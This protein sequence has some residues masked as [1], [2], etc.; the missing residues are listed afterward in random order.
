MSTDFTEIEQSE[1]REA[2]Q[3]MIDLWR[4][5]NVKSSGEQFTEEDL[6]FIIK[7]AAIVP[8][9][10]I[11]RH[12]EELFKDRCFKFNV[13]TKIQ[14]SDEF[15]SKI[16]NLSKTD[17]IACIWSFMINENFLDLTKCKEYT[18]Y[19]ASS[20]DDKAKISYLN[21]NKIGQIKDI[22]LRFDKDLRMHANPSKVVRSLFDTVLLSNEAKLKVVINLLVRFPYDMLNRSLQFWKY[23]ANIIDALDSS[24]MFVFALGEKVTNWYQYIE[25]SEPSPSQQYRQVGRALNKLLLEDELEFRQS[26]Y[27]LSPILSDYFSEKQFDNFN[28]KYRQESYKNSNFEQIKEVKGEDIR[29]YYLGSNYESPSG[30]LGH[31]CMRYSNCQE[32]LDIYVLNTDI[33]HMAVILNEEDKLLARCIVWFDGDNYY[34]DRVYAVNGHRHDELLSYFLSKEIKSV[35]YGSVEYLTLDIYKLQDKGLK[36]RFDFAYYPY[37]DSMKHLSYSKE[38]ISNER[39]GEYCLEQTNG[40]IEDE[41][42]DDSTLCDACENSCDSENTNYIELRDSEYR[43]Q[44]LCN[45]CAVYSEYHGEPIGASEAYYL[46]DRHTYVLLSDT[47][48]DEIT[49]QRILVD[50]SVNLFDHTITYY[51]NDIVSLGTE[52]DSITYAHLEYHSDK[53]IQYQDMYFL[54]TDCSVDHNNVLVPDVF[55]VKYCGQMY[56]VGEFNALEDII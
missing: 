49:D 34:H 1:L 12:S 43:H 52:K 50:D 56:E 8:F 16:K 30:D 14:V 13:E 55:L 4:V 3:Q 36:A 2:H 47:V 25:T 27:E 20:E 15:E 26:I 28:T 23:R 39:D 44:T 53:I 6:E 32:F 35:Y 37:M 24:D 9:N 45:N 5:L 38:L 33:V 21:Q 31:S 29:K 40:L 7:N 51:G 17:V 18:N 41:P 10:Y 11:Y 54:T 46:R 48:E 42:E 19:F 22:T